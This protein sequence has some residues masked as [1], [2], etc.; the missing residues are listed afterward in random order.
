MT[1]RDNVCPSTM[2][3]T[4]H[5]DFSYHSNKFLINQVNMCI[6]ASCRFRPA[7]TSLSHMADFP[8]LKQMNVWASFLWGGGCCLEI[9]ADEALEELS[10]LIR[11]TILQFWFFNHLSNSF[12]TTPKFF[13]LFETTNNFLF[14][15]VFEILL[16]LEGE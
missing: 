16:Q 6:R 8:Q 3:S 4:N 5:F 2:K 10:F 1:R 15:L 13:L 9:R 12:R 14:D 11:F 7:L